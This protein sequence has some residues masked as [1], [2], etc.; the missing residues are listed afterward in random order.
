MVLNRNSAH[1]FAY[2]TANSMFGRA[3]TTAIPMPATNNEGN[4]P[5]KLLL[6]RIFKRLWDKFA[7]RFP[8]IG[9]VNMSFNS[10]LA[11]IG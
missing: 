6:I 5:E 11:A 2:S 3:K 9:H 4:Y 8:F 1:S 7:W 10:E